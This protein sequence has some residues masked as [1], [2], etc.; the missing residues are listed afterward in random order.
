M[1]IDN[2]N[3]FEEVAA[4]YG[5]EF[6]KKQPRFEIVEEMQ[7][8][9]EWLD[10]NGI[11]WEDESDENFCYL[12]IVRTHFTYKDHHVSVVNGYGTYG[13]FNSFETDNEGLLEMMI[14]EIDENSENDPIG[15]LTADQVITYLE[16]L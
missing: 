3:R 2:I 5:V 1:S 4:H 10:Q 12:W 15:Y 13:G 8:L 11:E 7:K 16:E 9:R 6:A 14:G